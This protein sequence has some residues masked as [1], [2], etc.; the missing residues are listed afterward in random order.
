MD[1]DCWRSVSIIYD[2]RDSYK[3]FS[4]GTSMVAG[5]GA[6]L[7][8]TE[9]MWGSGLKNGENGFKRKRKIASFFKSKP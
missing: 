4:S 1:K 2:T 7:F 3:E 8:I 5:L 6:T 9:Y